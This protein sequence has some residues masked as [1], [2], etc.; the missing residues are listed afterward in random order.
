MIVLVQQQNIGK[1]TSPI[2]RIAQLDNIPKPIAVLVS[3][4]RLEKTIL[5]WLQLIQLLLVTTA[6]S[7]AKIS[8]IMLRCIPILTAVC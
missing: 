2:V 3:T 1:L 7:N 4:V 5:V 8:R 6:F